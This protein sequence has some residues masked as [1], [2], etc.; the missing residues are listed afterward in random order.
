MIEGSGS[1]LTDPDPG[2]PKTCGSGSGT[3]TLY[4]IIYDDK[5]AWI[6][7]SMPLTNASGSRSCYFDLQDDF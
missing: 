1:I 7:G 5:I 3:A 6:G 4:G 2:G